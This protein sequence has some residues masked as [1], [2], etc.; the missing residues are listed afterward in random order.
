MR[1]TVHKA[2]RIE[3][4][5]VIAH[6]PRGV[7]GSKALK[8]RVERKCICQQ[9]TDFHG[10]KLNAGASLLIDAFGYNAR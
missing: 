6:D 3:R 10:R 2:L 4:L 7:E 1:N 5:H 9:T 8:R